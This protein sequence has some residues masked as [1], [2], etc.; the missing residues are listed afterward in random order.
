MDLTVLNAITTLLDHLRHGI[1][2]LQSDATLALL[3]VLYNP[4]IS[5]PGKKLVIKVC[6]ILSGLE[7]LYREQFTLATSTSIFNT[8]DDFKDRGMSFQLLL[9]VLHTA[10]KAGVLADLDT[11][12]RED[13]TIWIIQTLSLF[14]FINEEKTIVPFNAFYNESFN[15]ILDIKEELMRWSNGDGFSLLNYPFLFSAEIKGYIIR[16]ESSI[17]MRHELQDSFFRAM[18]IGVN[19]PYLQLEI[20]RTHI[21][22]DTFCQLMNKSRHDLK[23]QLRITFVG[24]EGIDEGG[25]QKEFFQLITTQMFDASYGMFTHDQKLGLTWF[26]PSENID[27]DATKEFQMLG[28]LIALAI[29]NGVILDLKFPLVLYKKLL[30]IPTNTLDLADIDPDMHEGL[31][32]MCKFAESEN[33]DIEET[34]SRSFAI[35][36]YSNYG[37]LVTHDLKIEGS[38]IPLTNLNYKG[39]C[40]L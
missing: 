40:S 31:L 33:G 25:V 5:G 10:L 3:V 20:R 39:K 17:Q 12:I 22:R 2:T 7:K 21:V 36:S 37:E 19:T 24:E 11:T 16:V 38:I 4:S 28:T 30:K 29:Y 34:Y 6:C 15:D 23:K 18:F 26:A 27:K 32:K 9:G 8:Y 13:A 14:A 35:Q 1:Q